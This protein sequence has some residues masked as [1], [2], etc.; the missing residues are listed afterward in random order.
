MTSELI[1][2]YRGYKIEATAR[3][4]CEDRW[5]FDYRLTP[6]DGKGE[7]RQRSHTVNGQMTEEAARVAAIE[8]ARTEIDNVLSMQG[9]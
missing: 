1:N 6:L 9:G 5:D 4:D 8:V 3:Q 2:E 7:V